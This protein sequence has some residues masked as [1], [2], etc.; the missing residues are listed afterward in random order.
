M[1]RPI[2]VAA[3]LLLALSIPAQTVSG[4]LRTRTQY[5][6]FVIDPGGSDFKT[7][8]PNTLLPQGSS[9]I[10]ALVSNGGITTLFGV[11][12]HGNVTSCDVSEQGAG[13]GAVLGGSTPSPTLTNVQQGPHELTYRILGSAGLRGKIEV[14][15]SGVAFDSSIV[16]LAAAVADPNT[17]D[18]NLVTHSGIQVFDR[19]QWDVRLDPS[20]RRE[21]RILTD[22]LLKPDTSGRALYKTGISVVF[23]PGAFCDI[24]GYGADCGAH[25]TASDNV[26]GNTRTVVAALSDAPPNAPALLVVG[27]QRLAVQLPGTSCLL[28]TDP[29]AA[30]PFT[31]D[32]TGYFRLPFSLPATLAFA[33][34]CQTVFLTPAQNLGTTNGVAIRFQ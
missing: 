10:D 13:S 5:G 26:T 30:V 33:A 3:C 32:A 20:G 7:M 22:A 23:T 29:L 15:A 27:T 18:F 4:E 9:S 12:T 25:L 19:R 16:R 8:A 17:I 14:W 11:Q 2:L 6:L 24:E 28:R 34:N 1:N 31:I 21:V